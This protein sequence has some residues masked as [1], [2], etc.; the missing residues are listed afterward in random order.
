MSKNVLNPENWVKDYSDKMLRF[1]LMRVHDLEQAK[2][3]VS[4]TFLTALEK[5]ETFRGESSEFTWLCRI[6]LNKT[7]DLFRKN[8]Y[9]T[10]I[11][12]YLSATS[13]AFYTNFFEPLKSYPF[14]WKEGYV[15]FGAIDLEENGISDSMLMELILHCWKLLPNKLKTVFDLVYFKDTD[16]KKVCKELAISTSNVWVICHRAKLAMKNCLEEKIEH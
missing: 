9:H 1:A 5:R 16:V 10:D 13:E 7:V 15:P 12:S 3:L 14:H 6:L 4:D 8:K 2:D 11:D